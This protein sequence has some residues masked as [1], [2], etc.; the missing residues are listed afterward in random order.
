MVMP[1]SM[2]AVPE[3]GVGHRLDRRQDREIDPK[4][5]SVIVWHRAISRAKPLRRALGQRGEEAER[6]RRCATAAISSARPHCRHAAQT[7]G[8]STPNSRV[9]RV[10]STAVSALRG[11][12][13]AGLTPPAHIAATPNP[14]PRRL[15]LV[16]ER[17]QHPGAGGRGPDGEA[18]AAAA[19]IDHGVVDRHARQAAIGTDA[20]AFVDLPQRDVPDAERPGPVE[21]P[22]MPSMTAIP[23]R[24]GSTP[25]LAQARTVA[26]AVSPSVRARSSATRV[27]AAAA[28][29]TPL[30]LPAVMEKPSISG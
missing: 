4:G 8:C 27:S 16:H 28:S 23:L 11:R 2:I 1:Q 13:R 3:L 5:R 18:A 24:R 9:N 26:N 10:D 17:G 12:R 15:Q 6:A 21:H 25:T 22:V 19:G 7:I 14:P 29:L 20:K 30:E